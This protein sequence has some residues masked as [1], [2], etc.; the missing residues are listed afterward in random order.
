V[1]FKFPG[2]EKV[3]M[4]D[5]GTEFG[6]IPE[7]WE[8]KGFCEEIDVMSG[9]TPKT[10]ISEYWDGNIPFFTPKDASA[11][12]YSLVTEKSI[13]GLGLS[14]CNSKLYP[15]NTV[16]ITARGTV[17]KCS[18]A[19]F[20]MAMNQSCYALSTKATTTSNFF[21]FLLVLNLVAHLRKQAIGGVFDT[22]TVATF[23]RLSILI[24]TQDLLAD[25][26]VLVNSVFNQILILQ[27]QQIKL[28][29]TRDLLLPKLV[30]GEILV[31]NLTIQ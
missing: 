2:H 7:G 3:K 28:Q 21:I 4:V 10:K 25:F 30:S 31:D 19:P 14:K 20:D 15:K 11:N 17:G 9:G 23:E 16:F 8:V 24:P 27:K 1:D 29:Q 6:E 5:S 12:F 22:I 13:T 18:L 26:S